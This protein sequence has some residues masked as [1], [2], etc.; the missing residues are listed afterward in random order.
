MTA[1]TTIDLTKGS[2]VYS[3]FSLAWPSV[4]QAILSNCYAFNDFIF[5]GHIPNKDKNGENTEAY[6]A[7]TALAAT[8]GLQVAFTSIY[9]AILNIYS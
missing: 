7:T 2:L 1:S 9:I 8:V 3:L 6:A 4:I 5:V